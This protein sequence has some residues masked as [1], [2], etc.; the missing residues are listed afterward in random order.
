MHLINSKHPEA[1]ADKSLSPFTAGTVERYLS[2]VRQFIDY[3][4]FHCIELGALTTAQLADFLACLR[5]R[6]RRG[7][8]N[9]PPRPEVGPESLIVGIQERRPLDLSRYPAGQPHRSI[10]ISKGRG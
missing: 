3:L 8:G 4:A 6:P 10:P 9:L 1:L 2:S 5:A 7:Q